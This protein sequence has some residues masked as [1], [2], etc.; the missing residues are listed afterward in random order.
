MKNIFK[1]FIVSVFFVNILLLATPT[2]QAFYF[3][4]PQIFKNAIQSLNASGIQMKAQVQDSIGI[5]SPIVPVLTDGIQQPLPPQQLLQ[6]S[7]G[8]TQSQNNNFQQG[9][10]NER[11]LKDIKRGA[12]QIT[13]QLKQFEALVARFEKKG[14]VISPDVKTK[15]EELKTITQKFL[16]ATADDV[17]NLDMN[18]MGQS[19]RDLENERQNLEQ[20]DNITR[21]MRRIERNVNIFEK[22]VQ[23]LAKQNISVPTTVSENL[24]KVKTAIADIKAGKMGNAEDIFDLMRNLDENRGQMEMLA[25]WPQTVKEM[26]RQVKNLERE[27][28]RSKLSVDRLNKNGID[29]SSIY[30]QFESA[31]AKLKETRDAAK[32]KIQENAEDAFDMVQNDFFG[33]MDDVMESQRTIMTMN[34]FGRF[35]SDFTRETNKDAQRIKTLKRQKIDTAELE[36]LLTQAKAKGAE[37]KDLFKANPLDVDA[38]IEALGELE[39]MKQEF[40]NKIG[41]LTGTEDQ[42]PWEKGPQQFKQMEVSPNLDKWIPRQSQ[43]VSGNSRSGGQTESNVGG[44]QTCNVNGVEVPGACQ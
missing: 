2:A 7:P 42:M 25:R 35:Q 1:V 18:E 41:E 9:P 24:G 19:M 37:V 16:S 22:Q 15:I 14:V 10:D 39:N 40:D 31:I 44:G 11:I 33:Q 43:N 28:K 5:Q 26:D 17:K 23:K 8:L 12:Q 34:N 13:R 29:L 20:M 21:E 30:S 32:I 6:D 38:V 3:E 27:L 36:D 4:L